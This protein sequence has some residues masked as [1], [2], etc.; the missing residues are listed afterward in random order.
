MVLICFSLGQ[1]SSFKNIPTHWVP[2]V[3]HHCPGI[4]MILV[5]TKSD[6][7][8]FGLPLIKTTEAMK[9]KEKIQAVDYI[10]CSA[11]TSNNVRETFNLA[12]KAA[13]DSKKL[14]EK[15]VFPTSLRRGD[16]AQTKS[17]TTRIGNAILL[18]SEFLFRNNLSLQNSFRVAFSP[19]NSAGVKCEKI[20]GNKF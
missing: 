6:M 15:T 3:R 5:G 18:G 13:L 14:K 1:Q 19:K 4:P 7:K 10:K 16:L 17:N 8:D 20:T 2:E 12:V 11:M 9:V